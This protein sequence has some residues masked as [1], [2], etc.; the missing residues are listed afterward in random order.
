M[1]PFLHQTATHILAER[2]KNLR[3]TVVFLPNQTGINFF[4]KALAEEAG[5][6]VW[7]PVCLTP[8]KQM[9]KAS[10]LVLGNRIRLAS[11]LH[12]VHQRVLGHN[13]EP[14]ER[15]F[16]W[17]DLLLN[18]FDDIDKYL[19]DAKALYAN[20]AGLRDI[21]EQFAFLTEDQVALIRR[22]WKS[23]EEP[24]ITEPKARFLRIWEK[25]HEIYR[26]FGEGLLEKGIGYEGLL[27]R[28]AVENP[29]TLLTDLDDIEAAYVI[30]F[31]RLNACE[32]RFFSVL[33]KNISTQ[34]FYDPHP[35][36][37]GDTLHEAGKFYRETSLFFPPKNKDEN[38]EIAKPEIDV[39]S[40]SGSTTAV[41]Y[42]AGEVEKALRDGQ[43]PE[44]IVLLIPDEKQLVPLLYSLP[45]EPAHVNVTSGL[46]LAETP[47]L[48]LLKVLYNLRKNAL[49][50]KSGLYF[51]YRD[52]EKA[53]QHPYLNFEYAA[54]QYQLLQKLKKGNHI[55]PKRS[56]LPDRPLHALL[57]AAPAA[58]PIHTALTQI[59]QVLLRD[60]NLPPF[61]RCVLQTACE[62]A[63]SVNDIVRSEDLPSDDKASFML[64]NNVFRSTRIPFEGEP[65]MGMQ[66][67]GA[68]E[69]RN[70]DFKTVIIPAM[71]DDLFPGP[72]NAKTYIPFA[73]RRA[74]GLP[75]PEDR[76][77]E[78][79]HIFFRLLQRARKV[80]L[81][82]NTSAGPLTT[83]EPSRFLLRLEADDFYAPLLHKKAVSEKVRFKEPLA[84]EIPKT[85]QAWQKLLSMSE[86]PETPMYPTAI[87]TY[88]ECS[89]RF[90]FRYIA[91]IK[92]EDELSEIAD[93]AAFG[94]IFHRIME[95]LYED[96]VEK[97]I[98]ADDIEALR[99][100]FDGLAERAFKEHF[101]Y[102]DDETFDFEGETLIHREVIRKYVNRILDLDAA[103]AP[104]RILGLELGENDRDK[105]RMPLRFS[106]ANGSRTIWLAGK[107]D[108]VDE[109]DGET[110]ILDYK[111]GG[112]DLKYSD[113]PA[114]F[115]RSLKKRNKAA[116][117]TWLYGLIYDR[118]HPGTECLQAGVISVRNMF[119]PEF[120]PILKEKSD[121][122]RVT[123]SYVKVRN[124]HDSQTVFDEHL[125]GLFSEMYNTEIPFAQ[126]DRLEKCQTCPYKEICRR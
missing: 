101:G 28:K 9:E 45:E 117:Q 35:F 25:L 72:G 11:E 67:M 12:R 13:P 92:E 110:R 65:V 60:E 27:H 85:G 10:G 106:T 80:V 108:R 111:T 55:R 21:Y 102:A 31:N 23:Y 96:C 49:E 77:A 116:F 121:P 15:F 61:E 50:K 2:G 8:G 93:H 63:A 88:L 123:G 46:G 19:A 98:R 119:D 118:N 74:F 112:D 38:R 17:A 30:G 79:S 87:N 48:S 4:R 105:L 91:G 58:L 42:A 122:A 89:L 124:L 7:S 95:W 109:K 71:A 126:T 29:E 43:R 64:L 86:N 47:A 52:V 1:T 41:K 76:T 53:L 99:Q 51:R 66:I 90:Y 83:G 6:A 84:I 107:I 59:L 18:D 36:T 68:L 94:S 114:L 37:V 22:F 103:Y 54:E 125:Q 14:F 120:D 5:S 115:D 3:R 81:I 24:S 75:L 33:R 56:Q 20:L 82:C 104:F 16:P 40:V 78:L 26:T 34:F 70:L 69:T 100:R 32:R 62:A 44:D 73:L 97:E 57:F 39:V 113:I